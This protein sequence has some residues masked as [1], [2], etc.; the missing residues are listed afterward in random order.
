MRLLM[1]PY[2]NKASS[3]PQTG[4]HILAQYDD[5]SIVVYQAHSPDIGNF[6]TRN[7]YFG[8]EFKFD[9]MSWIKTNFLWMMYR[10]GWGT[11]PG[12]EVVLAI[13]IKRQAFDEILQAAIHAK[14]AP[15]IYSSK[16][17]WQKALKIS[18]VRLQWDPENNPSGGKL[19]RRAI[20][21]GLRGRFLAAYARDWIVHIEDISDFVQ[22]QRQKIQQS[23]VSL[24]TPSETVYPVTLAEITHKLQ[25]FKHSSSTE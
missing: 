23:D 15:E 25:L 1:E 9:R 5:Q 14:F 24:I 11:K 16:Q 2:L 8:G 18:D 22:E 17:E 21:L 20:Q 13:W 7:G 12:Q 10:S 4:R 3:W 6:A 19:Q